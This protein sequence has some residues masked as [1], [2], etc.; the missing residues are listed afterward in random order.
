MCWS[1]SNVFLLIHSQGYEYPQ[2]CPKVYEMLVYF[3]LDQGFST[4]HCWHWG[5]YLLWVH[6]LCICRM[7]RSIPDLYPWSTS[8][9]NP[10]VVTTNTILRTRM[11]SI[12]TYSQHWSEGTSLGNRK[13]K[14]RYK[15]W[16]E[17]KTLSL[18]AED[19]TIHISIH[20]YI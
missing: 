17:G 18:F 9:I 16:K 1:Q 15:D 4:Q 2:P 20:L 19:M 6:G 14:K 12:I 13:G 8:S 7:L 3:P 11:C 10:S 5:W